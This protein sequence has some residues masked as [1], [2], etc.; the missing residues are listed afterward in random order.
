MSNS[1]SA[2]PVKKQ[3]SDY[4]SDKDICD[5][6]EEETVSRNVKDLSLSVSCDSVKCD[7]RSGDK[8]ADVF[9]DSS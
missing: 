4:S 6:M 9:E 3:K 8:K 7:N 1:R 5:L 2:S